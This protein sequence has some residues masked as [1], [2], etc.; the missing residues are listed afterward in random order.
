MSSQRELLG[1]STRGRVLPRR[2]RGII[3]SQNLTL[4]RRQISVY[5]DFV[6]EVSDV[7]RSI[8]GFTL[9]TSTQRGHRGGRHKTLLTMC[10]PPFEAWQSLTLVVWR[11]EPHDVGSGD[12][13]GLRNPR[14][15]RLIAAYNLVG[16]PHME[17]QL[18]ASSTVF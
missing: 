10:L 17:A 14:V 18:T 15:C 5:S 2:P 7:A 6:A 8:L 16:L 3:Y 12:G 1:R 11:H 13:N 4:N 9:L